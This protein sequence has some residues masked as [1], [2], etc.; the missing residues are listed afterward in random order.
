MSYSYSTPSYK[1]N[2]N[3]ENRRYGGKNVQSQMYNRRHGN[4]VDN[5]VKNDNYDIM[6]PS[7]SGIH[8]NRDNLPPSILASYSQVAENAKIYPDESHSI[9]VSP[10]PE[11]PEIKDDFENS[12]YLYTNNRYALSILNRWTVQ[13]EEQQEDIYFEEMNNEQMEQMEDM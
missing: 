4:N 11:K 8:K 12:N 1:T 5:N 13:P 10:T 7:L 6:F 9:T 2:A 3:P